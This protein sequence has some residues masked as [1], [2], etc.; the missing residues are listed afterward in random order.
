M[1][2]TINM[3]SSKIYVGN[4][5][6]NTN[7]E[8]LFQAFSAY[9][10]VLE[11]IVM[12]DKE[13]KRSRGFGFVTFGSMPEAEAAIASMNK[14]ELDGRRIRVNLANSRG[15]G[16]VPGWPGRQGYGGGGYMYRSGYGPRE[17][18]SKITTNTGFDQKP[19]PYNNTISQIR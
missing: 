19:P 7:D 8:I 6:W 13:T 18:S 10:S 2:L 14:G 15:L 16:T 5:S 12:K 11:C 3:A 4:L 1:R 9:G 17:E